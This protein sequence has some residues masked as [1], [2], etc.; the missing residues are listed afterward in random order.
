METTVH[1]GY[2][3]LVGGDPWTTMKTWARSMNGSVPT[4][5]KGRFR[6]AMD[7]SSILKERTGVGTYAYHLLLHMAPLLEDQ[8]LIAWANGFRGRW[9]DEMDRQSLQRILKRTRIPGKLLLSCWRRFAYP[10]VE[11]LVGELDLFHSTNFFFHPHRRDTKTV[12][13]IHDL[14]FLAHPEMAERHGGRYFKDVLPEYSNQIDHFIAVS[15]WTK[16]DLMERLG[17]PAEKISVVPHGIDPLFLGAPETDFAVLSTRCRIDKPYF[18]SVGTIEPRKNY[19]FLIEAFD[20]W[21]SQS[22]QD[23]LLVIAGGPGWG[24]QNVYRRIEALG[25]DEWVRMLGY[26]DPKSLHALYCNC[27]GVLL[28]TLYEGF[29][30]PA[31]EAMACGVPVVASDTSALREVMGGTGLLFPLNST[32]AFV[33]RMDTILQ[34]KEYVATRVRAARDRAN[35]FTWNKAAELTY[36]VYEAVLGGAIA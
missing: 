32:E 7:V 29:C 11:T 5:R 24:F 36:Q 8:E 10:T 16:R 31:L 18:L 35:R 6:I 22:K 20:A 33:N 17:V 14:F 23:C 13:T 2:D 3:G 25:A 30:L 1:L 26:M 19:P 9:P 34:Q 27:R 15:H 12:A 28:T 4:R 21:R